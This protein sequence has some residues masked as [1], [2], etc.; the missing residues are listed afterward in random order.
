MKHSLTI[1]FIAIVLTAISVVAALAG[2]IGIIAME[3]AN[4]YADDVSKL[5]D[6]E[7]DSI[8]RTIAQDSANLYT[9]ETFGNL[10]YLLERSL[11]NDPAERSD[12]DHWAVTI[13]E[14]GQPVSS[15]GAA[16]GNIAF[17]KTFTLQPLYPIVYIPEVDAEEET[18]DPTAPTEPDPSPT[19][20]L[21][22]ETETIWEN[23]RLASYTL[24]YYEAPEYTVTV[25]LQPNVL[26]NSKLQILTDMFP[27][28]Y[29][30]IGILAASLILF[31]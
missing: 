28:R 14:N 16:N 21:Y 10:P 25:S 11:F 12:V 19:D 13:M 3:N 30:F 29:T 31:S 6:L 15:A 22:R 18:P 24:Y 1:K 9:V 17:T 4:L 27:Y 23:G 2:G 26:I 5:Q 8:A 20:Y 7:Y